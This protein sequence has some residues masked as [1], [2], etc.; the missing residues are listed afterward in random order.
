MVSLGQAEIRPDL[1]ARDLA[2]NTSA[3]VFPFA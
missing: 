2:F 1:M 3:P